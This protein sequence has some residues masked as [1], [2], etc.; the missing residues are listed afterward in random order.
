MAIHTTLVALAAAMSMIAPGI[1]SAN[2][3]SISDRDI[4]II[5]DE[6]S[7]RL[8]LG[9]A[10]E[11]ECKLTLLGHLDGQT[12]PKVANPI[13]DVD[14]ADVAECEPYDVTILDLTLP[15]DMTYQSFRN[16]LPLIGSVRLV[17]TGSALLGDFGPLA[18]CLAQTDSENPAAGEVIIG[19][20]SSIT[21]FDLDQ[22]N[23][24]PLDDAGS[25]ILCDAN[26]GFL[27][28]T[29]RVDNGAGADIE[30]T[31]I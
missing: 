26:S 18:N 5:F 8:T 13:G 6:A 7:E 22:D 31:L 1:A 15:W 14:H 28:G 24:I 30:V 12:I 21:G 3:L 20:G 29:G 25:S 16:N 11:T 2:D 27:N 9:G 19:A 4:Y 10:L 23:L 17:I